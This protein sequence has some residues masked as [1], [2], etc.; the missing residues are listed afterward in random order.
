MK[1]DGGDVVEGLIAGTYVEGFNVA[2]GV[3]KAITG[4][5]N[6]VGGQAVK[7]EGVI[8]VR[9]MGDG[10]VDHFRRSG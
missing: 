5:T 3:R 8:R 1:A 9:T 10:D 2:K 4:D 6:F 7:H